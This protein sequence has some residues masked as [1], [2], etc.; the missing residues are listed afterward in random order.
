MSVRDAA[1]AAAR[2]GFSVLPWAFVG[3]TKKPMMKWKALQL[4][5]LTPD[6]VNDW[7]QR[8][9]DH[10]WGAITGSVSNVV[11]IDLD[12][13]VALDWALDNLPP[14]KWR[15]VTGRGEHWGYRHPGGRVGNQAGIGG[16]KID[17][18]GDGGW[19]AMPPSI[20]K[21]GHTY[22][23]NDRMPAPEDLPVFDPSWL[24]TTEVA[25]VAVEEEDPV[26]RA[27]I[28]RA[29]GWL[30]SRRPAIQGDGGDHL[31]YV[32]ACKMVA[33]FGLS[34]ADAYVALSGWNK[35]CVPPWTDTELRQKI[36][37]AFLYATQ[38]KEEVPNLELF[39]DNDIGN[40]ER[41]AAQHGTYTRYCYEFK[42][43]FVWDG[44]C[45][46]EDKHGSAVQLAKQTARF[47]AAEAGLCDSV[48]G[49]DAKMKWTVKSRSAA[50]LRNMMA[51]AQS[52]GDI[53]VAAEEFD[54]DIWLLN[55]ESGIVDLRTGEIGPHDSSRLCTKMTSCGVDASVRT[56]Y[57]DRFM[58]QIFKGD[59]VLVRYVMQALGY[60]LTGSSREHLFF[61]AYGTGANGK[62]TLLNLAMDIMGEYSAAT[63][64]GML[65]A[66]M[67]DKHLAELVVLKGLRMAVGAE[68]Q[69]GRK[70]NE[71]RMKNL[72]GGDPITADPKGGAYVTFNPTHTLWLLGNHKPDIAGT[73]NGVW[74]RTRLLPF[75]FQVP[76]SDRDPELGDK[77]AAEKE[78]ILAKMIMASVD[79]YENGFVDCPAV[80]DATAAYKDEEDSFGLFLDEKCVQHGQ[81]VAKKTMVRQVYLEWA[82]VNSV[83]EMSAKGM[84]E[85]LRRMGFSEKRMNN[86]R[87]WIGLGIHTER[88]EA[89]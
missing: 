75:D 80:D 15:V 37:N 66:R 21:N 74:R 81:A 36:R 32:T 88:E 25:E 87:H 38:D 76:E 79:W 18:R 65:M 29:I 4:E 17:L 14:T 45:W 78:G 24:P 10:N 54:A 53:P 34:E 30:V 58:D 11:V 47:I 70:L 83:K 44:R 33:N 85:R 41:F 57:F 89:H 26:D 49:R 77:L 9:P 67:S 73:D 59:K 16:L 61:F 31:T 12:D 3:G 62:G 68:T 72:T 52:E 1:L 82:K 86:A 23:W 42:S 71:A 56:P 19:V 48:D 8:N 35:T 7:W 50:S 63:P 51:M 46:G 69:E 5:P 60:S 55:T 22:A 40:G 6:Q 39:E 28:R 27:G 84:V 64:E 13:S 20:H 43:W 2:F